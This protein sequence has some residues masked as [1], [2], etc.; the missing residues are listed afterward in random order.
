MIMKSDTDFSD[1]NPFPGLRPFALE[2]SNLFF[3]RDAESNEVVLKLLKN[4]YLSV[5][6]ASGSGKSSLVYGGV[7]PKI[8]NAKIRESSIWRII[9]FR[10]GSDPFGNLSEALSNGITDISQKTIEKSVILTD[11]INNQC[12]FSDVV[13][14]YLIKHDDNFIL[15]IDQFEELFRYQTNGETDILNSSVKKFIDFLVDSVSKPD[16]NIFIILTLCTEYL[17]EC[18]QY[19]GLTTLINNSNYFVP[20]MEIGSWREVIDG[21]VKF[22]GAKIE[23]ELVELILSDLKGR[24]DQFAV[25]Q[26]AMMRT[27]SQW[28]KLDEPDKPISRADYE[29]AGTIINAISFHLEEVYEKLSLRGREI[30]S[31]LFKT[32]TRKSSDNNGLRQPSQIET[33]KSIAGCSQDELFEVIEKFRSQPQSFI[34]PSENVILNGSSVIDIQNDCIIG[35]WDRLKGWID[36][37]DNSRSMYLRLS[38]AAALY[39]QGKSGL[40]KPPDL[41]AAIAW[42]EKNRPSLAWAVQYNPA[43]ERVMVFLRTSEKTYLEEEQN[44]IR[45]QARKV[46]RSRLITRILGLAVLIVTAFLLYANSQKLF[47]ERE[48]LLA[49]KQRKQAIREKAVADSFA[50]VVMKHNIVSDS[51]ENAA[52]KDA[53]AA[54]EQKVVADFQKSFAEKKTA[55]ALHQKNIAVEQKDGTQRLRMLSIGKSMSLKSLQLNGQKDLQALLAYQAYLFNKRNNGPD[56]DADIYA[57]LYNVALQ[58]GSINYKSFKGHNGDIRSIAFIPGKNEFFTSGNDGKVLKWSLENNDKTLQVIYSGNDIIEV[59]A[60]SPDASWLA[61]GSSNSSIRMIPLKGN[62]REYSMEGHKGGIKSLIFS[63]DGKYLYSAALD[64]KVLKWDIAARTS[65]NA[66]TGSIEI[67]SIDISSKGKYLAGI[68]PDGNVV[69]WDPEHNADNFRIETGGKNIKVIRFNPEN[70]LLALGDANGTVE[71]W[72]LE[73]HKKISE[74]KAHRGQVNDIQFNAVLKQMATSGNDKELKIFNIKDPADLTEPPVSLADNEGFVLVM[75]FSPDGQMIISGE[76]EGEN[77]L[78][79]RPSHAD[80]LIRDICKLA[81]RNM[82]SEEWSAYVGKDIPLEKTCEVKN[83]NIKVEPVKSNSK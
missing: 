34:T 46:K 41:Q 60:V 37:E 45:L 49:E 67:S 65:I 72:D 26:H 43:F 58:N 61:C 76:S 69:V 50:I 5:I 12:S 18:S 81:S 68:S 56:N 30:C 28:Q 16:V 54:R 25:L 51:T 64:G 79:S 3:G 35:L 62:S 8:L 53:A 38:E 80:Y 23:P 22:A 27:W 52:I 4:R 19:K 14:K 2:D 9:S 32:I 55:E 82:T 66:G 31:S 11:L 21:P 44:K 75:Q 7:L 29:L 77:N 73:L 47:S 36:E 83:Y 10:P 1:F 40:Y 74:V 39:Q 70:N 71:L 63:Y 6:G 42:R 78:T 24:T 13:R 57:G 20:E 48:T 33:I 17:G 15:V 59:L